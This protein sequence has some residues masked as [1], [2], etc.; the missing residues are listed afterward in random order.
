MS[1]QDMA[2]QFNLLTTA[3]TAEG[4][5]VK[6]MYGTF[7]PGF[8]NPSAEDFVEAVNKIVSGFV[9]DTGE[10]VHVQFGLGAAGFCWTQPQTVVDAFAANVSAWVEN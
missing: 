4:K 3:V 2:S 9:M 8:C 10:T 7:L 6:V 5:A 1:P